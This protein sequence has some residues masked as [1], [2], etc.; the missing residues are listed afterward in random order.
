MRAQYLKIREEVDGEYFADIRR[1]LNGAITLGE[2]AYQSQLAFEELE[3]GM[4]EIRLEMKDHLFA[5]FSIDPDPLVVNYRQN[6]P[7]STSRLSRD[8]RLFYEE[9]VKEPMGEIWDQTDPD[10][11]EMVRHHVDSYVNELKNEGLNSIGYINFKIVVLNK[12]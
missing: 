8:F 4:V 3:V 2:Q 9:E 10:S 1:N 11:R 5:L 6:H 12:F 7:G